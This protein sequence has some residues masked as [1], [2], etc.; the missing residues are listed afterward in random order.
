MFSKHCGRAPGR[1]PRNR[2]AIGPGGERP[3]RRGTAPPE[4]N[5]PPGGT[6]VRGAARPWTRLCLG[7][8][9][10]LH[11]R[12]RVRGGPGVGSPEPRERVQGQGPRQVPGAPRA[13]LCRQGARGVRA[14]EGPS[15]ALGVHLILWHGRPICGVVG[16]AIMPPPPRPPPPGG[17]VTL[18]SATKSKSKSKPPL[19]PPPPAA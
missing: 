13:A 10:P 17:H 4:G 8:P 6:F 12:G 15:S 11:R 1:G 18:R 9:P 3:L 2:P 5:G 14:G 16:D 7:S 19:Q